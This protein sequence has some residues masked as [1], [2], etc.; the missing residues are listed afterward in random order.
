MDVAKNCAQALTEHEV[1]KAAVFYLRQVTRPIEVRFQNVQDR[2]TALLFGE[3][4]FV[5]WD[6]LQN[7][8][9]N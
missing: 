5:A 8:T 7:E 9:L 6:A 1:W 4:R 2:V 3:L